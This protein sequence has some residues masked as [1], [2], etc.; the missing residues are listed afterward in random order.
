M[1]ILDF[2]G[3]GRALLDGV[4]GPSSAVPL[5]TGD[6]IGHPPP[7]P[8]PPPISEPS[9]TTQS[10]PAASTTRATEPAARLHRGICARRYTANPILHRSITAGDPGSGV[11]HSC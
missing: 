9:S 10:T 6:T 4:G 2:P 5:T 11:E 7:L 1:R 8:G 3:G